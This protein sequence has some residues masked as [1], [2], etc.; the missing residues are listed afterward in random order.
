MPASWTSRGSVLIRL[1]RQH[2]AFYRGY[3]DGLDLRLLAERYSGA[4]SSMD[5][6]ELVTTSGRSLLNWITQQLLVEAERCGERSAARL[7][8]LQTVQAMTVSQPVQLPTLAEFQE[9]RDPYHMY[10]EGE[11][12]ELFELEYPS[13]TGGTRR[14]AERNRRL[15]RRQEALL[16]LIESRIRLEPSLDD[17]VSAWI[18]SGLASYLIKAQIHTL[19]DL[20]RAIEAYGFHW[21]RRVPRIGVKAARHITGWLLLPAT[22][23]ALGV[24]LT[25]RGTIPP[26]QIDSEQIGPTLARLDVVPLERLALPTSLNGLTG[27]NRGAA[28]TISAVHDIDAI[29]AWLSKMKPGSHTARACRKEAER[30]LLWCVLEARKPV[31]SANMADVQ[32]YL[33]FLSH[34]GRQSPQAWAMGYYLPQES[35]L[36]PRGI[37]RWSVRW[38]PFEGPLSVSSQRVALSLLK[39][40]FRFLHSVGYLCTDPC[41]EARIPAML[42]AVLNLD[43]GGRKTL[44]PDEWLAAWS[45]LHSQPESVRL[46]RI[47]LMLLLLKETGCRLTE[48]TSM[49]RSALSS[50]GRHLR[51]QLLG[52]RGPGRSI[53][54][55]DELSKAVFLNYRRHGLAELDSVPLSAPLI[56]V[57]PKETGSTRQI[58]GLSG[59][60]IYRILKDYFNVVAD[61]VSAGNADLAIRLRQLSTDSFLKRV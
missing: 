40:L 34:L 38:R 58:V 15:R 42:D 27:A 22:R 9:E 31:S 8:R 16:Q 19:S 23:E 30:F 41:A 12:L 3:L 4:E 44:L 18:D 28:A 17:P 29:E 26:R 6:N 36:G 45:F 39:G 25:A 54:L 14:I 53:L 10:S 5:G 37:D 24:T 20:H 56:T 43:K 32:R 60:R 13:R 59:S 48:L 1:A 21:Y 46:H 57:I 11:L 49:Q 61:N 50:E 2:F 55:S 52:D 51:L 33:H 7:L 35:W 47:K